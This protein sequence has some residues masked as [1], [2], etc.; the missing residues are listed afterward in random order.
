MCGVERGVAED[1]LSVLLYKIIDW[2]FV[3][4]KNIYIDGSQVKKKLLMSHIFCSHTK[5]TPGDLNS[6]SLDVA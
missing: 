2:Y 1:L 6:R 5:K 4:R 3:L